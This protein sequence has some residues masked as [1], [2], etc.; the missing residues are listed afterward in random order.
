MEFVQQL[1]AVAP[2]AL[3]GL[4]AVVVM[5]L[6][7]AIRHSTSI[8]FWVSTVGLIATVA[9]G[10]AT[11]PAS[12]TV[13]ADMLVA[14]GTAALFDTLL[15]GAGLLT[16]LAA[17]PYL[18]CRERE[19]DEFYT[20]L[21]FAVAGA[22]ILAHSAH[23][24]SFFLG[25]ELMSVSFYV[26]AGYFRTQL[27]S[28]EAAL[29]YFLLG[30][31][32]TG[33][34]LYGIAM[35]YGSSGSLSYQGIATQLQQGASLPTLLLIGLGLLLVGVGFKLAIVPFHQWVPDVYQGAPTVVT[36]FMSTV[37][38]AAVVVALVPL[39]QAL[40]PAIGDRIQAAVAV[41]SAATILLGNIV[42]A[43]QS[44]IKRM[45][46][47]S[48]IAHAGYLLMGVVAQSERGWIGMLFYAAAY[49]FMQL[50]AFVVVAVVEHDNEHRLELGDYTGLSR[51]HPVLAALMAV[52]LLSLTGIPP[53][54]GFVGK[55]YLF[56]AALEAG[57]TWLAVVAAVGTMIS[58]YF[59]L[60]V[61][62][63]MYFREPRE[64][65]APTTSGTAA[66]TLWLST[67]AVLVLG[68]LPGPLLQLLQHFL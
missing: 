38:K 53:F 12:G 28:V 31:F 60:G 13:F 10:I 33:F 7:A 58:A 40:Q 2:V 6:D 20:L 21:L 4:L 17:R 34:L 65:L 26:L 66:V 61:L 1:F 67:A 68:I 44:N 29:K 48:S 9:A 64:A 57:Y 35:V 24:V 11:L 55:Y 45:L 59:Y 37:G 27:R 22:I 32:A 19:Y 16:L 47:Y 39:L 52:F 5:L 14:G 25:L 8:S 46:A 23:L 50:G 18:R 63:A 51:Q 54:A 36:A 62:V 42:A 41:L 43:V 30:A 56:I 15:A 3:A 49:L